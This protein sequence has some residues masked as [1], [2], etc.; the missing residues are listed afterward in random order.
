M[1]CS[2]P[3]THDALC[4]R[5]Q[6]WLA[7]T[8][9]CGVV[10]REFTSSATET[11]DAIGWSDCGRSSVLVECKTSR[12]DFFAERN[13]PARRNPWLGVGE[14]R[15]YFTAPGLLYPSELPV[16]WGLAEVHGSPE[17]S[18]VRKAVAPGL[19]AGRNM[20]AE[21]AM[22]YSVMRR[23]LEGLGVDVLTERALL[24]ADSLRLAS[25]DGGDR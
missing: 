15:W 5:A 12:A 11:P 21:M 22:M 20:R 16:G 17:R 3:W 25:E 24:G 9:R 23:A 1:G 13:K 18:T 10:L 6:R 4:R 8:M 2:D 7:G 14:F 19:Q